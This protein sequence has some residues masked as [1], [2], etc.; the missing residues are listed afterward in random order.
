MSWNEETYVETPFC[1]QL[2]RLGWDVWHLPGGAEPK[3]SGRVSFREVIIEPEL[4]AALFRINPFLEEDQVTEVITRLASIP[5]NPLM[6]ANAAAT[7]LLL[8]NTTVHENRADGSASPTVRYIDFEHPEKNHFLAVR[9]YKVAVPGTTKHIIPDIV[10]FANGIPLVVVECKSPLVPEP[11]QEAV[12]QLRRY[13][14]SREAEIPE[15]NNYLFTHNLFMVATSRETARVSTIGGKEEHYLEW[16]DPYPVPFSEVNPEGQPPDSQQKLIHGM[17]TP[18]HLLDILQNF[19]VFKENDEGKTIK[20]V[21][22][23]QQYRAVQK[24]I[25]RLNEEIEPKEKGGVV[26]HTQGSGKSLTMVFLIRAMRQDP[27]LRKY[28]IVLITDRTDLQGQLQ[29]TAATSGEHVYTAETIDEL[30]SLLRSDSSNIV[31][32]MMQKFQEKK[33]GKSTKTPKFPI[34]NRSDKIL[35]LIDE[36][37]RTQASKLGANVEQALPNCTRIAFTGTPI[38]KMKARRGGQ[39]RRRTTTGIFGQY[40]DK[41]TIKQSI[42]DGSTLQIIYEGRTSKDVVKDGRGLDDLFEDMFRDHTE[43]EKEVIKKKYGTYRRVMEA[44]SRIDKI[45]TDIIDHYRTNILPNG[46]KAQVVAT[47]RLAAVRYKDALDRALAQ[48]IVSLE[49]HATTPDDQEELETL[50]RIETDVI[51]SGNANDEPIFHPYTNPVRHETQIARFKKPLFADNPE[52]QDGLSILIVVDMLITGFDAPIEQIMYLDKR[53][54]EHNLLQAIARVNRPASGKNCGYVVDYFGIGHHLKEALGVFADEDI[55]GAFDQLNDE[56]PK[57]KE[58]YTKLIHFFEEADIGGH[59]ACAGVGEE[60]TYTTGASPLNPFGSDYDINE[61]VEYLADEEKRAEFVVLYKNFVRKVDMVL[62]DRRALDYIDQIKT[63]GFINTLAERR[64]RDRTLN[65]AGCGEKVRDLIDEYIISKGINPK[66]PPVSIT[67]DDF[68]DTLDAHRTNKAKASEMAHAI[69]YHINERMEYD[70]EFYQ[71]L[72]ERLE[73]L[74]TAHEED[75]DTL[76]DELKKFLEE[77]RQGRKDVENGLDPEIEMPFYD[78]LLREV[79]GSGEV[80]EKEKELIAGTTKDIVAMIQREIQRVDFWKKASE[81]QLLRRYIKEILI[82]SSLPDI[83]K[84]RNQIT[85]RFMRLAERLDG[86]LKRRVIL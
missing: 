39:R 73:E 5:P 71:S 79:Y 76:V 50:R 30:K 72:S 1:D 85:D 49:H 21:A 56:I 77:V 33:K 40:I 66:V 82:G 75:W 65:I 16:K 9:Q 54:V 25:E 63:I 55:E 69:R 64:Y 74:L 27:L 60:Y 22:R 81:K 58:A 13:S 10:L 3:E 4:R 20:V 29:K 6:E 15:G 41:Y 84:N 26:W 61:C 43:E 32:G 51:I 42:E 8:N 18:T 47:S 36:A 38:M 17:L 86:E 78:I 52:K 37:H 83:L 23:Y 45:A 48:T 7:D 34:L 46:F 2:E 35:L 59:A 57:M 12:T 53:I 11:I 80:G 28:K 67:S 70:P 14:N 62:P 24:I 31:M 44:P 68:E 19:S